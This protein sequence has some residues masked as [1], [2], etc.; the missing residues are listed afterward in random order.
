MKRR[1]TIQFIIGIL[2]P[3][4]VGGLSAAIT[5]N[6]MMLYEAS[7]VKPPLTPPGWV[8]SVVWTILYAL[9]GIASV[10]VWKKAGGN[11]PAVRVYA[12]QLLFNFLWPILFFSLRSYLLSFI[13]ILLLIILVIRT[14]DLFREVDPPAAKLLI[15]YLIWLLFAAYLNFYVFLL[16]K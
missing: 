15:P 4:A 1:N 10:R 6:G 13:W 8:F 12:L 11:S 5:Q 2:I 3:L 7:A 16:N 14:I 9:M